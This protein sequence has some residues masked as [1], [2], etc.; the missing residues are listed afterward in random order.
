MMSRPASLRTIVATRYKRN[1]TTELQPDP[2]PEQPKWETI[3]TTIIGELCLSI[4]RGPVNLADRDGHWV[5]GSCGFFARL[6]SNCP[7]SYRSGI[8]IDKQIIAVFET[9]NAQNK[10]QEGEIINE[11]FVYGQDTVKIRKTIGTDVHVLKNNRYLFSVTKEDLAEIL[12]WYKLMNYVRSHQDAGIKPDNEEGHALWKESAKAY[13]ETIAKL[14][15]LQPHQDGICECSPSNVCQPPTCS[16]VVRNGK[17]IS[18]TDEERYRHFN[19]L[20][21][22]TLANPLDQVT[23]AT[24]KEVFRE[25]LNQAIDVINKSCNWKIEKFGTDYNPLGLQDWELED[26][27]LSTIMLAVLQRDKNVLNGFQFYLKKE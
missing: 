1:V 18:G 8:K 20:L 22:G 3:I 12:W 23:K 26:K 4:L 27:R 2:R 6:S 10:T 21:E 25:H 17:I 19:T 24:R 15:V 16:L 9:A 7:S 13:V 11:L 5:Q 14:T